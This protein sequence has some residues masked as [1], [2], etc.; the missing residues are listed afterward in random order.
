MTK[1]NILRLKQTETKNKVIF[2]FGPTA[3]G[4]TQLLQTL[5]SGK[6][7][8]INADSVQVY[9]GLDI[10]SA[11]I[12]KEALK[13]IPHHL[14]DIL[15]PWE[16][17]N[18]ADFIKNA[19]EAVANIWARNLIPVVS[20]GTAFYFK[21][22]LYGLSEA[23]PSDPET[24]KAV[25]EYIKQV[26]LYEAHKYLKEVDPQ[27]GE[28]INVNDAYRISRALEVYKAS[29]KPLSSFKVPTIPRNNMNALIIGLYRNKE[30]LDTRIKQRVK[31]MFDEGI[32]NE[33]ASLISIGANP[34]WQSMQGIGY[35]EFLDVV[36]TGNK[37]ESLDKLFNLKDKELQIIG[38]RIVLNSVHYAKRQMTFFKSFANVNWMDP[39]NVEEISSIIETYLE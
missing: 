2:L 8:V 18:V 15:E 22:F 4:K 28:R 12:N 16:K 6:G 20:G 13:I 37:E 26:G 10:G 23:P 17:Y 30:T 9:R 14:L 38:E 29:G 35:K 32:V 31:L 36:W 3:V 39:D 19:D 27:S 1:L 34:S 33:I 11:K 5:F 25:E 21:H 7:E 24:R